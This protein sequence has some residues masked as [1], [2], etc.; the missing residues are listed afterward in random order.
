MMESS[1]I[2]YPCHITP[3]VTS[4]QFIPE[5]IFGYMVSGGMTIYDGDKEYTVQSG[6]YYFARRNHLAKYIKQPVNGQFKTISFFLDQNFLRIFSKEY[7]FTADEFGG[8][9]AILK[10]PPNPLFENYFQS[11]KPYLDLTGKEYQDFLLLKRKEIMLILLKTN[12]GMR[13]ILFDFSDPGKID[14][15]AFMNRNFRFNVSLNRFS[16][17]T[18]RSLTTFKRDFERIFNNTPGRWLLEKRLKEA[19]H[20]IGVREQSPSEAYLEVGFEDLSHFSFAF[21][22]MYGI[23][24]NQLKKVHA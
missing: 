12:P 22:K 1:N 23:S 20:L 5:H 6:D 3:T 18:G 14:L 19:Y 4:E 13:N 15:E 24:P 21:K 17:L 7:G 9:G 16:Y 11:V 10:L 2:T 8:K